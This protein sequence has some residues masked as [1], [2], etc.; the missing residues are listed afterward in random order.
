M[1]GMQEQIRQMEDINKEIFED[2][3]RWV[4][5]PSKSFVLLVTNNINHET[6]VQ[7]DRKA[8]ISLPTHHS[9]FGI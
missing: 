3:Q 1:A 7:V 9:E 6:L 2:E 8:L 4:S 5:T